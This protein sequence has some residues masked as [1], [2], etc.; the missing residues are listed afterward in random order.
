MNISNILLSIKKSNDFLNKIKI[1]SR[2]VNSHV[3]KPHSDF[4]KICLNKKSK[5]EEIYLAG[6]EKQYYNIILKDFSYFPV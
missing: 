5:Y 4:N 2:F 3:L 1:S 6:L